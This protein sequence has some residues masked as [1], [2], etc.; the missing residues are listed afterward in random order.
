MSRNRIQKKLSSVNEKLIKKIFLF[1]SFPLFG[2]DQG[3]GFSFFFFLFL[4]LSNGKAWAPVLI[5][6]WVRC[7]P[8]QAIYCMPVGALQ[9]HTIFLILMASGYQQALPAG[10]AASGIPSAAVSTGIHESCPWRQI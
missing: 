5:M 8:I 4:L 7:F 3:R 2:M 9:K 10:M 1:S 6:A